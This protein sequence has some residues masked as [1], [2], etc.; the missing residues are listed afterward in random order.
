MSVRSH[1]L[2]ARHTGHGLDG[3]IVAQLHG[4]SGRAG[5]VSSL[6]LD[7]FTDILR[8]AA[9]APDRHRAAFGGEKYDTEMP[10]RVV[11][12]VTAPSTCDEHPHGHDK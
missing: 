2:G 1:D 5:S 10:A 6:P 7:A 12:G 11:K 9:R 4:G 3:L 8:R